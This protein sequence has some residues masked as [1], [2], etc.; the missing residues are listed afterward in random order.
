MITIKVKDKNDKILK[1]GDII[2]YVSIQED[3]EYIEFRRLHYGTTIK[4]QTMVIDPQKEYD[5][6][7][8]TS[9]YYGNYYCR[10]ELL[11]LFNLPKNTPDD[12]FNECIKHYICDELNIN[13]KDEEE[14]Y[15]LIN[16][17]EI[18]G[19]IHENELLEQ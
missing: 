9:I 18:I 7:G 13:P 17:F 12:E 3:C 16:G 8:Y 11:D 14:F 1:N 5:K 19:N 4:Y 10:E 2:K 6:D 15:Y